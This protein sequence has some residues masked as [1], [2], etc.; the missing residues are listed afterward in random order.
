MRYASIALALFGVSLS[1]AAAAQDAASPESQTPSITVSSTLVLVPALVKTRQGELVHSLTVDDFV[2]T[3]DGIPQKL[4]LEPDTDAQPLALAVVV[5]TGGPAKARLPDYRGLDAVL[6]AVIGNV[7]HRVALVSFDGTPHLEQGFTSNTT[8]ITDSLNE[9][10]AGD[11]GAAI[12]DS[13][14]F[15]TGMLRKQPTTYRRA[16]LLVSETV[17][18][19]SKTGFEEALR[20]VEDTNTSIYTF[21]FSSTKAA[22]KHEASKFNSREPGPKNGCMSHDPD[23]DPDAHGNRAVQA[24]DCLS[25]LAPPLRLARMAFL[26]ATNDLKR[27]VPESVARLT[28]GE[29]FGFKDAR[30]LSRELAMIS[31]D[32]PNHYVLSFQPKTPHTGL[33]SLELRLRDRPELDLKARSAYWVDGDT[34]G[35]QP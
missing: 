2:L 34:P 30:S 35:K 27:N 24:L 29:Y 33:H 13:L 1:V 32:V 22:V 14:A 6:D 10:E 15:A 26:M 23:A 4:R 17:D 8:A 9:L 28:G 20:A 21:G 3:D 31:N 5:Q 25:M 12:L 7:P 11:D 19:G 18:N 16:V